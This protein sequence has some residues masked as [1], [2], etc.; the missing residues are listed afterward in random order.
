MTPLRRRHDRVEL[1]MM[2]NDVKKFWAGR[3]KSG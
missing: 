2:Q 3:K 1:K